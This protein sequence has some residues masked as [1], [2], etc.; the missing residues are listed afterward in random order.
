[1]PAAAME[2]AEVVV[3]MLADGPAVEAVMR[4]ALPSV[5]AG[6]GWA[7]TSTVGIAAARRLA[8]FGLQHRGTCGDAPV[9]GTPPPAGEGKGRAP[10]D[11]GDPRGRPGAVVQARARAHGRRPRGRGRGGSRNRRP[12]R[13]GYEGSDGARHRPRARRRGHGRDVLRLGQT[14]GV[15][16]RDTTI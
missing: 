15:G 3:T 14:A 8:D 10:E 6:A 13:A 7:Q 11:G 16:L 1:T 12:A 9:P 4:E 2:G 5:E